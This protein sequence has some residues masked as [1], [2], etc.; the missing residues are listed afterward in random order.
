MSDSAVRRIL[1]TQPMSSLKKDTFR[2]FQQR[3]AQRRIGIYSWWVFLL[4]SYFQ[5][6]AVK[7]YIPIFLI[8]NT[9]SIHQPSPATP[10]SEQQFSLDAFCLRI[11]FLLPRLCLCRWLVRPKGV[12]PISLLRGCVFAKHLRSCISSGTTLLGKMASSRRHWEDSSRLLS[13]RSN[14]YQ[15]E[16]QKGEVTG[17]RVSVC[18]LLSSN[19]M[20]A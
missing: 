16:G 12:F 5:S 20:W 10:S 3:T 11:S 14:W 7:W 17:W 19:D 2:N 8:S 4:L 1:L 18:P 13:R 9:K 15:G 6:H